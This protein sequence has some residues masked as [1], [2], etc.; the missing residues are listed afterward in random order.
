M[1]SG[2]D[3]NAEL[4][5]LVADLKAAT[6]WMAR[7]G[8]QVLPAEA[9]ELA[10]REI[11]SRR[12][13]GQRRSVPA[14]ADRSDRRPERRAPS[15]RSTPRAR[16]ADRSLA[17]GGE[18]GRIPAASPGP[19]PPPG[20]QMALGRWARFKGGVPTGAQTLEPALADARSLEALRTALGDCQRCGLHRGRSRIVFGT[21][22]RDAR[23][24]IVGEAPGYN[25]DRQG[26]PFVGKAG[27]MLDRMLAN[28]LGLRRGDVYITNVVKCRPPD[29]RNPQGD[30][31]A[32][33]APFLHAQLA[34]VQPEIVLVLGSIATRTLFQTTAGVKRM[35]GQWR[36]I[37]WKGGRSRAMAKF[38]PAYLLRQPHDKRLTFQDL[39]EVKR[40][41]DGD[42]DGR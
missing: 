20:G 4:A 26:E 39:Q 27:Q 13:H 37:S 18:G 19:A 33:C 9:V 15:G 11:P 8:A 31:I 5:A 2:G 14:D 38:H 21:G 7:C 22:R 1:T 35:R 41:L 40:A 3:P 30:E 24:M 36:E 10:P 17:S 29:N 12:R 32:R 28:V 25:E 34:M 16:A 42:G 6:E 23:L